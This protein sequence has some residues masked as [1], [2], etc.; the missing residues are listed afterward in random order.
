MKPGDVVLLRFPQVDLAAGKLRPALVVAM[1][2]GEYPDLL[3]AM[4]SSHIT[5]AIP[6]FDDIIELTDS[7]YARS[8]LKVR[9]VIRLARLATVESTAVSARL[10]NI[11]L[12]RLAQL[13]KRL[14]E[15]LQP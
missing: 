15:W 8:G 13:R 9:S 14:C 1:A 3:L 11:S 12:S 2:P 10:G 6:Q 5:Q 7:D 4:I